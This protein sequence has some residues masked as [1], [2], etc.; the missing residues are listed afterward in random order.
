M[1]WDQFNTWSEKYVLAF[2]EDIIRSIPAGGIYFGGTD[3]GRGIITALSESH[4][5]GKPFFTLTQNGLS[6]SS[7]LAYVR[8]MYGNRLSLLTEA[9]LSDALARYSADAE[10]RLGSGK[11]LPGEMVKKVD[12]K[13]RIEGQVSVMAVNGLLSKVL[14]DRNP[15]REFYIEESFPLDWMYPHLS[16]HG[17]ILK[18]NRQPLAELPREVVQEDHDYWSRYIRP[19]L[20]GWLNDETPVSE[21]TAFVEKVHLSRNLAGFTGDQVFLA[22]IEAQKAYAKLRSAVGGLYDWRATRAKSPDE[23][24]RM[25]AAADFAFRQAYALCPRSPEALFRY[26]NLLM[27]TNRADDARLAAATTLKLDPENGTVASLVTV[28]K[29]F[30]PRTTPEI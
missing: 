24:Q 18:L 21:V 12:G 29:N 9:D 22:D 5:Q 3:A 14:F 13:L 11:L 16:P 7:Y 2:G 28:L 19:M 27:R 20:G 1:A 8:A 26:L 25:T 17:L 10:E 6:D 30:K 4:A 15:G 23:Q